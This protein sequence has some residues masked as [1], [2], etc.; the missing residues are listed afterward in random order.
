[1]SAL[2]QLVDRCHEGDLSMAL[3]HDPHEVPGKRWSA[4]VHPLRIREFGSTPWMAAACA[5]DRMDAVGAP[6]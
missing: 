1:M 6:S 2:D 5:R 3:Y 4:W